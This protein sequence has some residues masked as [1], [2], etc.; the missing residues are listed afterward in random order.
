MR[1][2]NLK[3]GFLLFLLCLCSCSGQLPGSDFYDG[4]KKRQDGDNAEA[5]IHFEKALDSTNS[6]VAAAAAAEM[7]SLYSAGM[8][9]SAEK[10]ELAREKAAAD[11]NTNEI[12]APENIIAA[13]TEGRVA[14]SRF[15]Y[16][17]ALGLFREVMQEAPQLFFQ[18]PD[19]LSDLGRSFQYTATEREGIDLFLKWENFFADE[20]GDEGDGESDDESAAMR[21]AAAAGSEDLIRFRLLFFAGRIARQR[22]ED[23][24]ELF[25]RALPF[26]PRDQDEQADACIWYILDAALAQG[27]ETTIRYLEKYISQWRDASYFSDI[28]DKLARE[29][30]LVRQWEKIIG[31]F[32]LTRGYTGRAAAQFAWIIGRA[33]EE[34]LLSPAELDLAAAS[35]SGGAEPADG[36]KKSAEKSAETAAKFMRITYDTAPLPDG[37]YY[38]ILGAQAIKKPIVTLPKKHSAKSKTT[39]SEAM[40]FLLGFFRHNATEFAPQYIRAME[41]D[42]SLEDM[43]VLAEFLNIAGQYRQSIRLVSLYLQRN[44]QQRLEPADRENFQLTRRDL[45]LWYPRP[46]R[47]LVEKY[48]RETGIEPAL[49]FGLIHTE[50]AFDSN[51]VSR[52]GATGLTQLMPSTAEET[53]DRIRRQGGPNYRNGADETGDA[54]AEDSGLDLRNPAVNIHI[55]AVYLAYLNEQMG[56]PLLAALAYNGGMNRVR[57]WRRSL[58]ENLPP[59]LFLETVEFSE[60]REYGRKVTTAAVMYKELYY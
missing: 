32:T 36:E 28:T 45:E 42:F 11:P 48:A 29:L 15:R 26:V 52:V 6:Y 25:E 27:S 49:L 34:E 56:D 18:H 59:D 20:S 53:A 23:S 57:R 1:N 16:R 3:T 4:L 39:E 54:P 5:L 17:E 10:M 44:F 37:L 24:M 51:A 58:P 43:R 50:S 35:L 14:V 13:V 31:V 40:Q 30:I 55:G 7:L 8:E 12:D 41:G 21:E 38:R 33:I 9:I 60:T 19:L 47:E 2:R 22:D 46:Y